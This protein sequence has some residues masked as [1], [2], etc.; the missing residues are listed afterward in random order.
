MLRKNKVRLPK[1]IEN[2]CL[3]ALVD[4]EGMICEESVNRLIAIY[5]YSR[6]NGDIYQGRG[7]SF[8]SKGLIIPAVQQS[9]TP[10]FLSEI[11]ERLCVKY[12]RFLDCFQHFDPRKTGIVTEE[13]FISGIQALGM[14]IFKE[15]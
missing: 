11:Y 9:A 12:K 4:E 10:Q 6:T 7:R 8:D 14:F 3:E 15:A 2:S 5:K 13:M 1:S